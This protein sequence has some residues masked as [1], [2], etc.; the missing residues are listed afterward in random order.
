M[1][2]RPPTRRRPHGSWLQFEQYEETAMQ[3][4]LLLVNPSSDDE[5]KHCLDRFPAILGRGPGAAIC[6]SDRLVSR[7]HCKIG[8][9]DGTLIVED[10]GSR[11]GTLVNGCHINAAPLLPGD[12][13]TLGARVYRVIYERTSLHPPPP[14]IYHDR[15]DSSSSTETSTRQP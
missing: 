8:V 12:Q 9:K 15:A 3:A 10:L 6:I 14:T 13:L 7:D 4:M 2:R 1:A 5:R 11:N